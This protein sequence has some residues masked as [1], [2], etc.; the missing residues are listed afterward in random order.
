MGIAVGYTTLYMYFWLMAVMFDLPVIPMSESI[1][2]SIV[3]L[4]DPKIVGVAVRISLLSYI[5]AEIYEIA[6]VLPV[7]GGNV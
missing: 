5:Q 4:L 7:N 1:H 6:Y 3:V 2:T